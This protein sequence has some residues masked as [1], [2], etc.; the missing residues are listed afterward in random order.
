[1]EGEGG[2]KG[3]RLKGRRGR[4]EGEGAEGKAREDGRGVY[5]RVRSTSRAGF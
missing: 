5:W 4:M 3:S 2:W 1:M